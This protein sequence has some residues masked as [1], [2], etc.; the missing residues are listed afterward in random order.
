MH[1]SEPAFVLNFRTHSEHDAVISIFAREKGRYNGLVRGG[2][3]SRHKNQWQPGH[4]VNATWRARLLDHLGSLTG[5]SVRDYSAGLLHVPLGLAALASALALVES[6]TA[7]RMPYPEIYDALAGLL[8]LDEGA[9][10][11]ARYVHFECGLLAAIGYGLDLSS[12]ALTATTKGLTH[13]SPKTGRAVNGDAAAPWRD[14]LLALPPFL[15]QPEIP[16]WDD[17]AAGLA[18]TGHFIE[19]NLLPHLGGASQRQL[20]E[21]RRRLLD[22][23]E[24][25]RKVAHE[26]AA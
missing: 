17:I 25:R 23:V 9:D 7:E 1:W 10:D 4:L 5:E 3:S 16:S 12:C 19:G 8:P 26:A 14:K 15:L 22:L 11:L 24:K 20:K 2:Q 18:L 6:C 13:V 21:R